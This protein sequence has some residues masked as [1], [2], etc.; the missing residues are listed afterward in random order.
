M[1]HCIFGTSM[2]FLA[3][4]NTITQDVRQLARKASDTVLNEYDEARQRAWA[5]DQQTLDYID[6]ILV[7]FTGIK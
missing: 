2:E 1:P 6:E 4:E 7:S 3:L 5:R